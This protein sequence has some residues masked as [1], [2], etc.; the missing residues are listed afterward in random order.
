MDQK[1]IL[2]K[3]SKLIVITSRLSGWAVNFQL[4]K[5]INI[6]FLHNDFTSNYSRGICSKEETLAAYRICH[7]DWDRFFRCLAIAPSFWLPN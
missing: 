3:K 1:I 6:S 7:S 4:L 5:N 2:G